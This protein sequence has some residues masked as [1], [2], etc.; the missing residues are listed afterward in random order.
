RTLTVDHS[1]FSGNGAISGGGLF[2]S[3]DSALLTHSTF[4]G[5][6]AAFGGG[7]MNFGTLTLDKSTLSGNIAIQDGGIFNADTL[8]VDDSTIAHNTAGSAGG[9]I[10]ICVEGHIFPLFPPQLPCHGTLTLTHTSV[11]GHTPDDFFP[12]SK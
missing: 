8:A 5:N 3:G 11:T 4:S 9:G 2:V 7:I 12:M 6:G 10:Y 1:A